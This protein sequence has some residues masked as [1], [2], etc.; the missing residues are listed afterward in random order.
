MSQNIDQQ[1]NEYIEHHKNRGYNEINFSQLDVV[2]SAQAGRA[3]R[4]RLIGPASLINSIP[5]FIFVAPDYEFIRSIIL[6]RQP[7]TASQEF[8]DLRGNVLHSV[9]VWDLSR[10]VAALELFAPDGFWIQR[11][12]LKRNFAAGADFSH[13][14]EFIC[15]PSPS[16]RVIAFRASRALNR[17]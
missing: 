14:Y 17:L 11:A 1:C 9:Q 2:I 13:E 5:A 8:T 16:P 3:V 15:A 12:I 10:D 6:R 4:S 7:V